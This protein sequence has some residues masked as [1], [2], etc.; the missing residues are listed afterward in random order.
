MAGFTSASLSSAATNFGLLDLADEQL[1]ERQDAAW[2]A[3][4]R[5]PGSDCGQ[6][7]GG[8]KV[9]QGITAEVTVGDGAA[10]TRGAP[11]GG[12]PG[13]EPAA[14]EAPP[15]RVRE[16]AEAGGTRRGSADRSDAMSL[17]DRTEF[18]GLDP[19]QSSKVFERNFDY[20]GIAQ[21]QT[22]LS[23]SARILSPSA[24]AWM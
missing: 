19:S 7:A 4:C 17:T 8:I 1:G 20:A 9:R 16:R 13:A 15:Q 12:G 6:P 18:A 23:A 10:G 14:T 22:S 5:S 3:V 11:D 2:A 21:E 24:R